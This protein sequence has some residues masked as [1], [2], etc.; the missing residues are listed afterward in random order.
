MHMAGLRYHSLAILLD[1]HTVFTIVFKHH[2]LIMLFQSPCPDLPQAAHTL[3]KHVPIAEQPS[4]LFSMD[5][6]SQVNMGDNGQTKNVMR[7]RGGFDP[8]VSVHIY[9]IYIY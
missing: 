6:T 5:I 9:N 3:S 2:Y 4:K 8:C 7:L 1:R